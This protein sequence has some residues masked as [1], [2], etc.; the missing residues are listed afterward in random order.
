M[1][2][3]LVKLTIKEDKIEEFLT[4]FDTKKE[5]IRHYDGNTFLE[6]YQDKYDSRV[7][8]TY[9]IWEEEKFLDAYKNSDF[10]K[11]VWSYLKTLFDA[12]PE[13][14]SVDTIVSLT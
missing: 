13:A 6:V 1:F 5:T 9:S 14:W 8:F 4:F 3:R 10:F 12:K 2:T 7:F 11:E